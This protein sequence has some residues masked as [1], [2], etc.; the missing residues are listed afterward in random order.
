MIV[1]ALGILAPLFAVLIAGVL[2]G[3]LLIG[4]WSFSLDT[5]A[6][7][8]EKLSPLKG[9]GPDRVGQGFAGTGQGGHQVRVLMS[10]AIIFFSLML[11]Q[12]I[13]LG[14]LPAAQAF[15]HAV[16]ILQWV[17]WR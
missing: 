14:S 9:T 4:G 6:F 8:L 10:T 17:C 12:I 3:P 16:V 7:K 2:V 1:S 11:D 5:M 15:G 13:A